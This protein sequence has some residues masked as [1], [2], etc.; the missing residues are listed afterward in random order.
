MNLVEVLVGVPVPARFRARDRKES[1]FLNLGRGVLSATIVV[2]EWRLFMSLVCVPQATILNSK[3]NF[4]YLEP[5][6][7]KR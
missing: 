4:C 6:S 3:G 1:G 2:V 5:F 7:R